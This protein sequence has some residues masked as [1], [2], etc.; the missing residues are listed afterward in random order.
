MI[1]RTVSYPV[2]I[3]KKLDFANACVL[4]AT[5]FLPGASLIAQDNPT[6]SKRPITVADV[7]ETTRAITYGPDSSVHVAWF[8]PDGRQFVVLVRKGNVQQ[9]TNDFSLLLY[10]TDEAFES[11]KPN[12]VVTMSSASNRAGI[13]GVR[14]INNQTL[15]FIGERP[16][17]LPQVYTLDV[18]T[19]H[20]EKLTSQPSVINAFEIT[21]DASTVIYE[22]DPPFR[23]GMSEQQVRRDL[24]SIDD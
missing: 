11:P 17:E 14:W 1:K 15:A 5:Q 9:N 13:Q 6:T 3:R 2:R 8:S 4:A 18:T 10:R 12:I 22:A 21:A 24:K 7:V 23:P 19:K 16:G 20:L